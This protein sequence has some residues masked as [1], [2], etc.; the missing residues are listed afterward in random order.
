MIWF[1]YLSL[2]TFCVSSGR[3]GSRCF[4]FCIKCLWNSNLRNISDSFGN[5]GDRQQSFGLQKEFT[6]ASQMGSF[7][8]IRMEHWL[9]G[10]CLTNSIIVPFSA[11][12]HDNRGEM[13]F[14][15]SLLIASFYKVNT[16]HVAP[17]HLLVNKFCCRPKI[18]TQ[19]RYSDESDW[20]Q[21]TFEVNNSSMADQ[22]EKLWNQKL[23]FK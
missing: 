14:Y 8:S 18:K 7:Q 6:K 22:T 3:I 17:S 9:C 4:S 11:W 2:F 5:W 20:G 23:Y 15:H 19:C 12:L 21:I 13:F 1:I 16:I 10:A